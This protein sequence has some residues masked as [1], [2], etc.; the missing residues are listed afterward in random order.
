MST[1]SIPPKLTGLAKMHCR[2]DADPNNGGWI[3][4]A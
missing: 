1:F 3:V 2:L 4:L